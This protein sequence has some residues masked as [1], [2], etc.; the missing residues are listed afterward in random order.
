MLQQVT[1]DLLICDQLLHES[2]KPRPGDATSLDVSRDML[3]TREQSLDVSDDA[4][5]G[6]A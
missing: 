5:A 6:E 3:A 2:D 4:R 1:L